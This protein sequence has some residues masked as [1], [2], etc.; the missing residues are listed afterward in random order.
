MKMVHMKNKNKKKG[1]ISTIEQNGQTA[2]C[3]HNVNEYEQMN[4]CPNCS[5]WV[6]LLR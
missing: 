2:V 4:I 3:P 1:R 5:V 6:C